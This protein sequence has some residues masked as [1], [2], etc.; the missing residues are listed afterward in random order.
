MKKELFI[1]TINFI[2]ELNVEENKFNK[3]LRE[4]D[5]EFGG[6]FIHN[7]SIHYLT[8]LLKELY[9]DE[10]DWISYYCWEIDFGDKYKEGC[11]TEQDGTPIPLKTPEDLY[12]ILVGKD[13]K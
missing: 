13:Q 9:N 11:V 3:L 6:G 1:D 7:K 4:I 5:S 8:G 12:N 2:K 10:N